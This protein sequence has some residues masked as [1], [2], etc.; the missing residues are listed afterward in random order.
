M[1]SRHLSHKGDP[2]SQVVRLIML[3]QF[4]IRS[5]M[6]NSVFVV[7]QEY[8]VC[9]LC[10]PGIKYFIAQEM[11]SN[12]L[13]ARVS[14]SWKPLH[15]LCTVSRM[16]TQSYY[17]QARYTF[18]EPCWCVKL[19]FMIQRG[20]HPI[21]KSQEKHVGVLDHS[22]IVCRKRSLNHSLYIL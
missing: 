10:A 17:V 22:A 9:I 11:Q 18:R 14:E 19:T 1:H 3:D 4:H 21:R 5:V 8:I 13:C 20:T 15:C 2:D 6:T 16:K 12:V 7:S